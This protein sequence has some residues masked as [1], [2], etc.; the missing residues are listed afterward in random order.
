MSITFTVSETPW[1]TLKSGDPSFQLKGAYS[2]TDRAGLQINNDCPQG[3]R[4]IIVN[5]YERGWIECVA[6]VP[7]DDPTYMWETLRK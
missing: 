5:A 3:L 2:L 1:V 7:K 4:Q 6:S